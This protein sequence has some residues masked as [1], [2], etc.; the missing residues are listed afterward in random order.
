L[1]LLGPHR[2]GARHLV[3]QRKQVL[4]AVR[5]PLQAPRMLRVS[6]RDRTIQTA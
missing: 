6:T 4:D 2:H 5:R 3:P 1:A